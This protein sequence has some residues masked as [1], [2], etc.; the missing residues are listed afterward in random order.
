MAEIAQGERGDL[1]A[2]QGWLARAA[3][4]PRD[5]QW[6]CAHCGFV[7]LEW[8]PICNNCG[9]FDTLS[10]VAPRLEAETAA[11]APSPVPAPVLAPP[12]SIPASRGREP[13]ALLPRPPDDPGI[14]PEEEAWEDD[15]FEE[16]TGGEIS[17]E[18]SGRPTS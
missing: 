4:A 1:T 8:R 7:A 3:R 11:P 2:A 18:T 6:R 17:G 5:A 14:D 15:P 16:E 10:W 9:N 13:S 12:A